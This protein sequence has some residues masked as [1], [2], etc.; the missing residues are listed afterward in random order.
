MSIKYILCL[1]EIYYISNFNTEITNF[2]NSLQPKYFFPVSFIL[3]AP[4]IAHLLSLSAFS[5]PSIRILKKKEIAE[6]E[7][8]WRDDAVAEIS[9]RHT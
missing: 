1:S 7:R 3:S 8:G 9:R 6:R 2:L 5:L 4:I